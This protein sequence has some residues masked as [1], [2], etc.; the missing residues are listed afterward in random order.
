M[1]NGAS[2]LDLAQSTAVHKATTGALS[3][4]PWSA[5]TALVA[6]TVTLTAS[7]WNA[8]VQITGLAIPAGTTIYGNFTAVN[9]TSGSPSIVAYQLLQ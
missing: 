7:N 5:I 4:G 9:P 2:V 8:G 1:A 3:G 6:T